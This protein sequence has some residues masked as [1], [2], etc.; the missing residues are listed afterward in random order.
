M[1]L[2]AVG[3]SAQRLP[4]K[5]RLLLFGA[6]HYEIDINGAHYELTRRICAPAD[7]HITLLPVHSAR[8]WLRRVLAPQFTPTTEQPIDA[9]VKRW[10]LVMINCDTP[11]EALAYFRQYT[12]EA[13]PQVGGSLLVALG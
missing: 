13:L 7:V 10:P 2:L 3:C 11:Q 1:M 8:N 5:A 12:Q 9:L 4:R 6:D